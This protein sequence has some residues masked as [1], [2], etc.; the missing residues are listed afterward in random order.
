[1]LTQEITFSVVFSQSS[2][3]HFP[4]SSI[5]ALTKANILALAPKVLS[6]RQSNRYQGGGSHLNMQKNFSLDERDVFRRQY[7]QLTELFSLTDFSRD[8]EVNQTILMNRFL[9]A[10][11]IV[12]LAEQLLVMQAEAKK[13]S[14]PKQVQ[15]TFFQL[16]TGAYASICEYLLLVDA[17]GIEEEYFQTLHYLCGDHMKIMRSLL[18]DLDPDE[19][20]NDQ[21]LLVHPIDSLIKKWEQNTLR[22][23]EKKIKIEITSFFSGN[24]AERSLELAEID[25]IFYHLASNCGQ[26]SSDHK[27]TI[28][29]AATPDEKNLR[30][31]FQNRI[32][33]DHQKNLE[34]II[35]SDQSLFEHGV[36]TNG[37]GFGLG[38]IA[39]SITHAYGLDDI[40]EAQEKGYIGI[41]VENK[42]FTLWF[43]WPT[44]G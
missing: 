42:I 38:C 39:D 6:S 22:L 35:D 41:T 4:M 20:F 5:P 2:C 13:D 17:G 34:A 8:G 19:L 27:L 1:M 18:E 23:F 11:E 36:T 33:A 3:Q 26:Y 14:R 25:R 30:W 21:T 16:A 10:N 7:T 40:F 29:L 37:S 12:P 24:I 44:I 32:K 28:H 15:A 9:A 43:H 31:V